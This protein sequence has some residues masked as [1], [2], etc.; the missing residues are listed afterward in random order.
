MVRRGSIV[1]EYS[2]TDSENDSL[3]LAVTQ[4]KEKMV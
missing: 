2:N 4:H 1:V 3:N